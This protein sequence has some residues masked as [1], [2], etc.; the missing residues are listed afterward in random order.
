MF[1]FT[2]TM[3]GKTKPDIFDR[4]LL[5]LLLPLAGC[6]CWGSW[7]A[8]AAAAHGQLQLLATMLWYFKNF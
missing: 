4:Y 1:C 7:P 2:V 8:A 6:R 5:L 3:L